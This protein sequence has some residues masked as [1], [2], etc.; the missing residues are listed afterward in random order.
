[1]GGGVAVEP[2]QAQGDFQQAGDGLVL[3]PGL[4]QA[5]LGNSDSM[6]SVK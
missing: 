1:V 2:F 5:R 6:P 3:I 4:L